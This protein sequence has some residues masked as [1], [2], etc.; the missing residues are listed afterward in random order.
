MERGFWNS[1][2]IFSLSLLHFSS[3]FHPSLRKIQ[4]PFI[5]GCLI[6]LS[7]F[8]IGLVVMEKLKMWFFSQQQQCQQ[9]QQTTDK[10]LSK[11]LTNV[12][13]MEVY[14]FLKI[15]LLVLSVNFKS[16]GSCFNSYLGYKHAKNSQSNFACVSTTE[17]WTKDEILHKHK[18][19]N[20]KQDTCVLYTRLLETKHE[21]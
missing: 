10:F 6:V 16:H 14:H 3:L 5:H 19:L 12:W 20:I 17:L 1:S 15:R 7:S 8:T 18:M 9:H 4:I 11:R 13:L 2:N 21:L